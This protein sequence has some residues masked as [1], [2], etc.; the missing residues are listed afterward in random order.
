MATDGVLKQPPEMSIN[1]APPGLDVLPLEIQNHIFS[2]LNPRLL[3][4]LTLTSRSISGAAAMQLYANVKP[5]SLYRFAQFVSTISCSKDYAAMVHRFSLLDTDSSRNEM[6][7]LAGWMEWKYRDIPA[8]AARAPE[9]VAAASERS[10]HTKHPLTN[11]A[12]EKDEANRFPPMG[13]LLHVLTAC[14]NLRSVGCCAQ[15]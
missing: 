2:Y 1:T 6:W 10:Y 5:T 12:L 11:L 9:A 8:F 4:D 3:L 14:K 15:Q 13:A 7:H